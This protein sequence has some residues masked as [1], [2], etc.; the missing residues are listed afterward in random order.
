MIFL[1]KQSINAI[2]GCKIRLIQEEKMLRPLG[3]RVIIKRLEAEE[4]TASGIVLPSQ[5]KEKPQMAEVIAVSNEVEDIKVGDKVVF[6]K[7]VGTEI[8]M[9]G[10][11]VTICEIAD[12]L[13]I[14][15]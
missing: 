3:K 7:Y 2:L 15:E 11:E 14:V 1:D 6:K 8:K 4:K 13:A 9:D 5:A 10:E 12:I